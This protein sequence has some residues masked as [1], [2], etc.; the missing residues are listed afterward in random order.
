MIVMLAAPSRPK[1]KPIV[2]DMKER[3]IDAGMLMTPKNYC[4]AWLPYALDNACFANSH[5]PNWWETEGEYRWLKMLDKVAN[6]DQKPLFAVLPDVVGDW[7]ETVYR[8]WRYLP[9]L[10]DRGIL[11]AVALQDGASL[12]A[13]SLLSCEWWFVGGSVR[14]KWTHA[15]EICQTAHDTFGTKVHIGRVNGER[16]VRECL[17]IGADSCDGTGWTSFSDVTMPR[18]YA[19]YTPKTQGEL[20]L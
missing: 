14:W 7:E 5:T 1:W 17:R 13:A 15:E 9:E 11:S 6:Q 10:R 16:R 2:R 3:G 18:L 12:E 8:A 4:R 20:G 19:A